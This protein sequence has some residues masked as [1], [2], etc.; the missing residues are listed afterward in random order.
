MPIIQSHSKTPTSGHNQL[1]QCL[2]GMRASGSAAGNIIQI[3]HP[4]NI[5]RNGQTIL[6]NGKVTFPLTV[7]FPQINHKAIVHR[8]F[9]IAHL[10][11]VF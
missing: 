7:M 11:S 5:K 10:P 4:S 2:V 8:I 9:T 1:T 3:V 6:N